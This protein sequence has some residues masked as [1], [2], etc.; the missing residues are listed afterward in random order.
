MTTYWVTLRYHR[1]E[2]ERTLV[3]D[4]A[5]TRALAVIM[6][7]PYATVL[8]QGETTGDEESPAAR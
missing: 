3:Y 5:I 4:A 6:T 8:A 2:E 7:S 1:T